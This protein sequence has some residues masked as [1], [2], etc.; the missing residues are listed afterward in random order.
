MFAAADLAKPAV[1]AAREE[2]A[3]RRGVG[4]VDFA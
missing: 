4:G 3:E 2:V 1:F